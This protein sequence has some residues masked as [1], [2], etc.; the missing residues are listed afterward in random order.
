[1]A[2][3]TNRAIY[4]LKVM[5]RDIDPPVW[6]RIQVWE[7]ST[8]AQLHPVLQI[9][10]SWEDYHLHDFVI[11]RRTYSLPDSDDDLYERK[12]IDERR[13]RLRDVITQ[14]G[15]QFEY[16]Y[17]FGDSWYHDLLLEAI[18]MPDPTVPYPRCL[19]GERRTPPEDVGGT[20]GYENYLEAMQ[21]PG[22]EEHEAMLLW[23]GP[24]DPNSFSV[25]DVNQKLQNKFR[26][27]NKAAPAPTVPQPPILLQ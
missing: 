1:M 6:R 16:L 10:M 18:L 19:A 7:D 11:G 15:M 4:Q 2:T 25:S 9:V 5:L 27:R 14:I 21:D 20:I 24:F 12:V 26:S 22:H 13:I 8:L 17:D 3:K 23:R